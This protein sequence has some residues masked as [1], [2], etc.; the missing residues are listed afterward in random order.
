MHP[1]VRPV[2][3]NKPIFLLCHLVFEN[4]KEIGPVKDFLIYSSFQIPQ[5]S[6]KKKNNKIIKSGKND[7]Q[8]LEKFE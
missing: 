4:L 5:N 2:E 6:K 3:S 8:Y 1:N 7:L